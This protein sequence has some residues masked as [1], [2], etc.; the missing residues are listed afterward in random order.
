MNKL[1]II[2]LAVFLSGCNPFINKE[3][4]RKN[5]CNKRL[6]KVVRKC[7]ELLNSDTIRIQVPKVEID[8][9]IDLR[10]DTLKLD[11][12]IYLIKDSIVREVV[13][14]Y[15]KTEVYPKDTV[16]HKI[17][18]FSFSFWFNDGQLHYTAN[19][20]EIIYKKPVQIIKPIELTAL[21]KIANFI[22]GFM[23]P[24]IILL[25]ILFILYILKKALS[26]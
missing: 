1:I 12:I 26:P 16:T 25:I 13:R 6:E 18:G 24:I 20:P 15:I 11:S 14:K 5:K 23:W 21:E 4:K 3:L 2:I 7:P 8:T 19:R 10:I 17:E 9:F 22:S